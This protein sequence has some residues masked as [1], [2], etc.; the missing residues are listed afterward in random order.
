M[1]SIL[2]THLRTF[3]FSFSA[4]QHC[5]LLL[6]TKLHWAKI[7]RTLL[8]G[9]PIQLTVVKGKPLWTGLY[10]RDF[11]R[12]WVIWTSDQI[13][14]EAIPNN[15]T[16]FLESF[17][18]R[19]KWNGFLLVIT[20]RKRSLGQGNVF[21]LVCHSVHNGGSLSYHASQV[22]WQG[23]F[24][25]GLSVQGSLSRGSLSRGSLSRRVSVQGG[26]CPGGSLSKGIS[27][28]GVSVQGGSLSIGVSLSGGSL[29]R[30][31]SAQGVSVQGSL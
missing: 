9:W 10:L 21:T 12:T 6:L 3:S 4:S 15:L 28:Q 23:V 2:D 18:L 30:G 25:Q 8:T 19:E 26:I 11:M 7:M 24:V 27:D 22:T 16:W 1:L 29:P 5:Q 13:D 31:V 14:W 20:A 17:F